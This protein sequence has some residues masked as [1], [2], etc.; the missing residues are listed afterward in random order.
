MEDDGLELRGAEGFLVKPLDPLRLRR[1]AAALMDGGA[2][3]DDS[4]QPVPVNVAAGAA[5]AA[6]ADGA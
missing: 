5:L 4:Y 3:A 6:R 2:Y 1:A